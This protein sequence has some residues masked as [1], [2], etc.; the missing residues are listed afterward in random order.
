[1]TLFKGSF[2]F[3]SAD[4]WWSENLFSS[5]TAE[6]AATMLGKL[7]TLAPLRLA[8]SV[9]SEAPIYKSQAPPSRN[10]FIE[11]EYF[12][13]EDESG[14]RDGQVQIANADGSYAEKD[15]YKPL[16]V[17]S[18]RCY[19]S[20]P[21]V[22]SFMH[23]HGVPSISSLGNGFVSSIRATPM[24]SAWQRAWNR[25]FAA[26]ITAK[27]GVKSY[28]ATVPVPVQP[29]AVVFV[30]ATNTYQF[31]MAAPVP[32]QKF[33]ASFTQFVALRFLNG[34]RACIQVPGQPNQFTI[35]GRWPS[36]TWDNL[37]KI[38]P[39]AYQVSPF[40]TNQYAGIR[41]RKIGRA[42]FQPLGRAKVSRP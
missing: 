18:M 2:I 39:V 35:R 25:Y 14:G 33:T 12:R 19:G 37:G 3:S 7:A 5:D 9:T 17:S 42:F 21:K 1:M 28:V 13:V 41:E 26:L 11:L 8:L 29:T 23:L 27:M 6:N 31:T 4:G 22:W 32:S 34:R 15:N 38:A 40:T 10:A 24:P 30:P 16:L 20:S 36:V